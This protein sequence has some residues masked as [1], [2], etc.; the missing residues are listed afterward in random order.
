M[1][2]F[3]T[4]LF[5]VTSLY[6]IAGAQS[7][8]PG[9]TAAS[10]TKPTDENEDRGV[11]RI[12]RPIKTEKRQ[13]YDRQFAI[14]I[15]I[16]KYA[17][18]RSGLPELEFA[19]NDATGVHQALSEEFGYKS[20]HTLVLTDEAA[21]LTEMR[22]AF[23]TWLVKHEP[24][25]ND[26]VFVFFAGHGLIDSDTNE[27]YLAAIDSSS[28]KM[29][30]TCLPVNWVRRQ[31]AE[32]PTKHRLVILD[33]CYSGSLFK[34][35]PEN[36]DHSPDV[37][38]ELAF[39]GS[40][41]AIAGA[42][43]SETPQT[44][45]G[46]TI[47]YYL[48]QPAFMGMSAGRFTPVA[49]GKGA[50]RHSVFTSALL[51][52][53]LERANSPRRDHTFTFRQ[54]AAQVETR[55]ANAIGSRQIPDWGRLGTGDGDFIFRP[56]L[57]RETPR[58]KAARRRLIDRRSEYDQEIESAFEA[59]GDDNPFMVHALLSNTTPYPGA[60]DFRSFAWFYLHGQTYRSDLQYP[61][62]AVAAVQYSPN[63][64]YLAMA[65]N[66]WFEKP[67]SI[68]VD[69]A[70]PAK[71]S[72]QKSVFRLYSTTDQ[73][74]ITLVDFSNDIFDLAFHPK[75]K[76]VAIAQRDRVLIYDY[77]EKKNIHEVK[78][79]KTHYEGA[80]RVCFTKD[81]SELL[82]S[83]DDEVE[84]RSCSDWK[85]L[86]SISIAMSR[87]TSLA[88]LPHSEA[89]LIG[90][91]SGFVRKW[92]RN[93]TKE[94]RQAWF[95][96]VLS[97]SDS[98]RTQTGWPV[99]TEAEISDVACDQGGS[100]IAIALRNGDVS[101]LNLKSGRRKSL[102]V[103]NIAGQFN[104]SESPQ[105]RFSIDGKSL[106]HAAGALNYF[107]VSTGL[108][109][110]TDPIE[111]DSTAFSA[112][113][114]VVSQKSVIPFMAGGYRALAV[115]PDGRHVVTGEPNG[116]AKRWPMVMPNLPQRLHGHESIRLKNGETPNNIYASA[117]SP[118]GKLLATAGIDQTIRIWSTDTW[119]LRSTL[120]G[121]T[122]RV[123]N[124]AFTPNNKTLVSGAGAM[125]GD[126]EI[127]IWDV[128]T[129]SIK[130]RI[131]K[132]NVAPTSL[133]I[134][135]DGSL[136]A[137]TDDI[138]KD[139][140]LADSSLV[141]LWSLP[142]G[143][144]VREF[145]VAGRVSNRVRFA[146]DDQILLRE[147]GLQPIDVRTGKAV[148]TSRS[149]IDA[150]SARQQ[151]SATI[152]DNRVLLFDQRSGETNTQLIGH[153]DRIN[154]VALSPDGL[155][156]VTG[157][158]DQTVRIWD[159]WTGKELHTW[160]LRREGELGVS[161]VTFH[162]NGKAIVAT[163][164][165]GIIAVWHA[166]PPSQLQFSNE[167]RQFEIWH[168]QRL[169][170]SNDPTP[171][172]E[173]AKYHLENG[174]LE[175]AITIIAQ[176]LARQPHS[177]EAWQ[178]KATTLSEL[179]RN[180]EALSAAERAIKLSPEDADLYFVKATI[181]DELSQKKDA[182]DTLSKAI[183]L[184]PSSQFLM[185]RAVFAQE[186]GDLDSAWSDLKRLR[187]RDGETALLLSMEA[188]ILFD[189]G[190]ID[191]AIKVADR[192][193]KLDRQLPGAS[194]VKAKWN[195]NEERF[196]ESVKTLNRI[197]EISPKNRDA[198]LLRGRAWRALENDE[199]ATRDLAM[200][201]KL[202]PT[203][204]EGL[205]QQARTLE[206]LN[207]TEEA[208]PLYD[209]I[210]ALRPDLVGMHY[211]RGEALVALGR[212]QQARADYDAMISQAPGDM[213]GWQG[214]G[215]LHKLDGNLE[216][217]LKDLSEAL[218]LDETDIYTRFH[219]ADTL[220]KLGEFDRAYPEFQK[221]NAENSGLWDVVLNLARC[222]VQEGDYETAIAN[223]KVL[224]R[225]VPKEVEPHRELA[226]LLATCPV[227]AL[228]D[229]N[230]AFEEAS[231]ALKMTGDSDCESL[232]TIAMA[233]AASGR[234][235][236][237]LQAATNALKVVADRPDLRKDLES[238]RELYLDSKAYTMPK[239]VRRLIL[240]ASSEDSSVRIAA[241][242]ELG[243]R[244]ENSLNAVPVI[245]KELRNETSEA[246]AA[247]AFALSKIGPVASAAI[248]EL[249]TLSK[250]GT[251]TERMYA[252]YSICKIDTKT[253]EP[254]AVLREL[255]RLPETEKLAIALG[256]MVGPRAQLMMPELTSAL[257]SEIPLIRQ[258]AAESM[259]LVEPESLPEKRLVELLKDENVVI[260]LE[261]AQTLAAFGNEK[262][263]AVDT[264]V[265]ALESERPPVVLSAASRIAVLASANP[266]SVKSAFT[267]MSELLTSEYYD[268]RLE[269][270]KYLEH[271]GKDA[272]PSID[273]VIELL[274]TRQR[275]EVKQ[276]ALETAKAIG[277]P[278][279]TRIK[280]LLETEEITYARHYPLLLTLIE[281]GELAKPVQGLMQKIALD[282][283]ANADLRE[284]ALRVLL[285][286]PEGLSPADIVTLLNDDS[287]LIQAL[288][289]RIIASQGKD[290]VE[291]LLPILRQQST[292]DFIY[293]RVT[294]SR[295]GQ[296]A[297]PGLMKLLDEEDI[298]EDLIRSAIIALKEMETMPIE[299]M[300]KLMDKPDERY[301]FITAYA[302]A[303]RT[304]RV[305]D[306]SNSERRKELLRRMH[307]LP[308]RGHFARI[309][310][311][312]IVEE[313]GDDSISLMPLV[314]K[315]VADPNKGQFE[316]AYARDV[317]LKWGTAAIPELRR[318][319]T[320]P[321]PSTRESAGLA[322]YWIENARLEKEV[323]ND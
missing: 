145:A 143:E 95:S 216:A 151:I 174:G 268:I 124:L 301:I 123:I 53:L 127:I 156:A 289:S 250:E 319:Q 140:P 206:V 230:K 187:Q 111:Q 284:Y 253:T 117:F 158:E 17:G 40:R 3:V 69:A 197:L 164:N 155:T 196:E 147:N 26:A 82:F 322:L 186:S 49:D 109:L 89:L 37:E 18:N 311:L 182:F 178:L 313:L 96:S 280:E 321:V 264:L 195:F 241:F 200:L 116:L 101:L 266:K 254:I 209:D 275:Y 220:L 240:E 133:S 119:R 307:S 190:N 62:R 80:Y 70:S 291:D 72:S 160:Q 28:E 163:T 180:A 175:P 213:R 44:Q 56:T 246:R 115:S 248:E 261:A 58:E 73:R 45:T 55:V 24:T 262:K 102:K 225:D 104:G 149:W 97:P 247:A 114:P 125:L 183:E 269:G 263:I 278:T 157:S 75:K 315:I 113:D 170:N 81:G 154:S 176:W 27:G 232:Q 231:K 168:R 279:V 134:S 165:N 142:K 256:G 255:A 76:W 244:G 33:C 290:A 239:T 57:Y 316:E 202:D 305:A 161:S 15:G 130:K 51:E 5:V 150:F 287:T 245:V 179:G 227:A 298:S 205:Y 131:S 299:S 2:K 6:S 286:V 222:Q 148:D 318:L 172:R 41:S 292:T 228:R 323:A 86:P 126:G 218:R 91:E 135:N 21:T 309:G 224:V 122:H 30:E 46:D 271:L 136:L 226:R 166:T 306:E 20:G 60:P 270:L 314:L 288:A 64:K 68:Q 207:R 267:P 144:L 251:E 108:H 192:A 87:V 223:Y 103:E 31:L 159:T 78:R 4:F 162:P 303:S 36:E 320:S 129:H 9:E 106:V 10:Q 169:A 219:R 100:F 77:E 137:V 308:N 13:S 110:R 34:S 217:A 211:L 293:A 11:Q 252:A 194:I 39:H 177:I 128:N 61:A 181:H 297:I 312:T 191:E 25:A 139:K 233:H 273:E 277:P 107:D 215:M 90:E 120:R 138:D 310:F 259:R 93:E 146:D 50:D 84:R 63:G 276:Q 105:V 242:S 235:G 1:M 199:Q 302:L 243:D 47:N 171:Y 317:F 19:V 214:R 221:I 212:Q 132:Q 23:S 153:Q 282:T 65:S 152:I 118:D 79:K 208:I 74:L 173:Q 29:K 237:A 112:T 229:T 304:S 38:T 274:T 295:I 260:R 198:L 54:L 32:L 22:K 238:Q 48:D 94:I 71:E 167:Y 204:I 300:L 85:V 265:A 92:D 257:D 59:L 121:H 14:I 7:D 296:P 236:E 99:E 141:R 234:Y 184:K 201:L 285:N 203:N 16:N 281:L 189:R 8:T 193:L 42:T 283:Q 210:L 294:L 272:H 43:I 66:Y 88:E 98:D 35:L 185:K 258:Y 188:E 83:R 67:V 52:T 12:D 249:T